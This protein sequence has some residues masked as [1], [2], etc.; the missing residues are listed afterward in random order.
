MKKQL[1]SSS[2]RLLK[3]GA[4][5][6]S[7]G[8]LASALGLRLT[9]QEDVSKKISALPIK[10]TT[11][12]IEDSYVS[13]RT[14]TGRAVAGRISPLAFELGGTVSEISTDLGQQVTKGDVIARL[15]TSRLEA[16]KS[17]LIAEQEEVT[18]S[19]KLAERTL[20][21]AEET[22]KSGHA[23]AQRLDE[24]EANAI[25]L[26]ARLKRLDA[27]LRT[28]DVDIRRSSIKAPFSG[29]ITQR[30][31]D[32]GTVVG[33]GTSVLEITEDSRMEAHIGMP[34]KHANSIATGASVELRDGKRQIIEGAT[35]RSIVPIITGQT[36]TMMV[37][38]DLP[39][40]RAT[41]GELI[42]AVVNDEQDAHGAWLPIRALSSDVRGLWRVYKVHQEGGD[43]RVRFENVQILYTE[44]NR[45]F[46]TGTI[47]DGD[48]LVADGMNR[49]A[50][51]QLVRAAQ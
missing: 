26:K 45:A 4:I 14:F 8:L 33:A 22:F 29:T 49:L 7:A 11:V 28:L 17:Q 51:G 16:S 13:R 40:N 6:I 43:Q 3:A 20:K 34:P 10:T 15:D 46:V 1:P 38:F 39:E 27:S 18:A 50:P 30:M 9:A 25:T 5:I 42:N 47:S 37:T 48:I 2:P 32:E 35:V 36:R 12:K 44:G 41:R 21:R 31:V 23:S 24:A 19:L